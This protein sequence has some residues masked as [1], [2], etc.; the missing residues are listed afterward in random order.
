[1]RDLVCSLL[2]DA[3]KLGDLDE[4]DGPG[5]RHVVIRPRAFPPHLGSVRW[6]WRPEI[7]SLFPTP[8]HIRNGENAT[9]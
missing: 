9:A 6:D 7:K 2:A 3:E 5:L 8:I 1:M 4:P